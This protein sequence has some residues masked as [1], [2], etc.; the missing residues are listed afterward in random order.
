MT[1][2][3]LGR[4]VPGLCGAGA[5]PDREPRGQGGT[6]FSLACVMH[7]RGGGQITGSSVVSWACMCPTRR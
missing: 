5:E 2:V 7:L 1:P 6:R 3:V 4:R